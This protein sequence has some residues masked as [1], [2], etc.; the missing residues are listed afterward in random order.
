MKK[1]IYML[2]PL[3]LISPLSMA[4]EQGKKVRKA[5]P[6]P[7]DLTKP[8]LDATD[9]TKLP[10]GVE[11]V[12]IFILMGQSNMK[13][14]GV[15]PAEPLRNPR[16]VMMHKGTDD[17]FLARHPLHMIGSPKDFS[18]ADNAGVG[19]GLSFAQTLA[20][21]DPKTRIALIPCA[22]GGSSIFQWRKGRKNYD[23]AMRRAKLALA[24]GPKGKTRIAGVLWH[25][26]ESD[27]TSEGKVEAYAESLG[28]MIDD[29]RQDTGVPELPF[30]A[31]T[32][33]EMKSDVERRAQINKILLKVATI[34]PHTAC[35]DSREF[36]QH[37]GDRVHF[38]TATQEEH[39]RRYAAEYLKLTKK[40]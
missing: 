10:E 30:I 20:K 5:K 2:L 34:R 35:V 18:G 15:M 26:G 32:I 23:D 8:P 36:A 27:S 25:Q 28:K 33:G 24:Q 16:I 6:A 21:A 4:E 7:A 37:I 19:P 14:R 3:I 38:D 13:G 12:D 11:R 39:G 40:R 31:G 9:I 17:W 1:T 22:V 29:L